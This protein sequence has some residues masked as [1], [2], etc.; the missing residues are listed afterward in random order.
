MRSLS[1]RNLLFRAAPVFAALVGIGFVFSPNANA[2]LMVTVKIDGN[3]V[4]TF[5]GT[6]FAT[7]T[8]T[9]Y[10]SGGTTFSGIHIQATSSAP[11]DPLSN[12]GALAQT[13]VT[14]SSST[15]TGALQVFVEESTPYTI[16]VGP[17]PMLL[18]SSV[19]RSDQQTNTDTL[20]FQSF[21][22]NSTN[23]FVGPA[24]QTQ[25]TTVGTTVAPNQ[26]TF[27]FTGGSSYLL[28]NVLTVMATTGTIN[29][30][31]TSTVSAVPEPS[32]LAMAITGLPALAFGI[33]RRLR[34]HPI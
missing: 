11:G 19:S 21:V 32:T 9:T 16:P 5:S 23:A 3:T 25:D 28:K 10:S 14:T 30:S 12:T 17:G 8:T 33:R 13:S 2:T 29:V 20:T 7:N 31:G 34:R 22:T 18:T 4:D 6:G 26:V 27:S 1:T 15:G 24:Q